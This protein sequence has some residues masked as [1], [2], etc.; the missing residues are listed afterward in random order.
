MAAPPLQGQRAPVRR[1]QAYRARR[2]GRRRQA[3][4]VSG[5]RRGQPP[6]RMAGFPFRSSGPACDRARASP[7][8]IA[9]SMAFNCQTEKP[10][11]TSPVLAKGSSRTAR[12]L[13]S[14]T[15]RRVSDDPFHQRLGDSVHRREGLERFSRRRAAHA[16][17][18]DSFRKHPYP[19]CQSPCLSRPYPYACSNDERARRRSTSALAIFHILRVDAFRGEGLCPDNLA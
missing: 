18:L 17:F 10:R 13:P 16:G 11:I 6:R 5:N 15:I 19:H 8:R 14:A 7:R 4:R 2:H 12:R 1:R 3:P 9:S